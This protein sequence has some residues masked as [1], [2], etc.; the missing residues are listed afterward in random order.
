MAKLPLNAEFALHEF[1]VRYRAVL[2]KRHELSTEA[3]KG[4]REAVRNDY[5]QSW[6]GTFGPAPEAPRDFGI[7]APK[8]EAPKIEPPEIGP[9]KPPGRD[10][11]EPEM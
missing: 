3:L 2:A 11:P 4:I 8:I 1:S 6:P 10:G 9:P 7:E 5:A